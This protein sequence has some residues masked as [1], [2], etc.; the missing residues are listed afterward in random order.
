[1]VYALCSE[2]VPKN[3]GR[4]DEASRGRT[5]TDEEPDRHHTGRPEKLSLRAPDFAH[6]HGSSN[7]EGPAHRP[8]TNFGKPGS[9]H[10]AGGENTS[11]HEI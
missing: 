3:Q 8:G 10:G 4:D 1:M 9:K 7:C 11:N 6:V 5:P 2:S